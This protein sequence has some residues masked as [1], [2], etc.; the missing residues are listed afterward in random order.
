MFVPH[1]WALLGEFDAG[2]PV[3]VVVAPAHLWGEVARLVDPSVKHGGKFAHGVLV[4]RFAGDVGVA[5]DGTQTD[6]F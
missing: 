5:L 2:D 1:R 4:G 3:G 6:L